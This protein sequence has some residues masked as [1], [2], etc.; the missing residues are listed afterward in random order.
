VRQ[1]LAKSAFEA[2]LRLEGQAKVI[3]TNY[4]LIPEPLGRCDDFLRLRFMVRRKRTNLLK[5]LP[6]R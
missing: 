2:P 4:V 5:F 1:S 6:S 3:V